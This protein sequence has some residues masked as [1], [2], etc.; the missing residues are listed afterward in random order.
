MICSFFLMDKD[1]KILN[2]PYRSLD[3]VVL[4]KVNFRSRYRD[5]LDETERRTY[6]MTVEDDLKK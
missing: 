5:F 2:K 6:S 4:R 3:S 1:K